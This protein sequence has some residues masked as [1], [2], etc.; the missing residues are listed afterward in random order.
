MEY[1][2]DMKRVSAANEE[3]YDCLNQMLENHASLKI[4]LN[5][6]CEDGEKVTRKQEEYL[7]AYDRFMSAHSAVLNSHMHRLMNMYEPIPP[8]PILK[9][10]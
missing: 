1:N 5:S 9:R 6:A 3:F 4:M 2:S 10:Q 8:A 7:R